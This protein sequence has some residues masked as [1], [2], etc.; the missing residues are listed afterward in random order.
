MV[1]GMT[2]SRDQ[3][4]DDDVFINDEEDVLRAI[5]EKLFE[6]INEGDLIKVYIKTIIIIERIIAIRKRKLHV[7]LKKWKPIV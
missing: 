2:N 4:E 5:G 7:H 6:A 3:N 1:T